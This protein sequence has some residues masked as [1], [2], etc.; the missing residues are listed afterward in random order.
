M[1]ARYKSHNDATLSYIKDA[2]HRFHIFKD[3]FLLWRASKK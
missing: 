3:V 2:L 1:Y